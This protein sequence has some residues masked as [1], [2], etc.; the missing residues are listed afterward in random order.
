MNWLDFIIIFI[1]VNYILKGF[2]FGLVLSI[3][4]IARVILS[5][6]IT[7]KLYPVVYRYM[8]ES[9]FF[10]R[11]FE[12]IARFIS[13][14]FSNQTGQGLNIMSNLISVKLSEVIITSLLIIIIFLLVNSL[15]KMIVRKISFRI[16]IPILKQ[17]DKLGGIAF[18]LLEG[19]FVTLIIGFILS[20]IA[21]FFPES[22][23][24]SGVN[25]SL[26]LTY[27]LHNFNGLFDPQFNLVPG[28]YI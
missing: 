28:S 9:P 5:L 12:N 17:L 4:N 27:V 16:N 13:N 3:L 18:G 1:L 14:M 7:N 20:P 11:I 24:G 26:I 25:N 6:I 23:I 15:L 22:L 19:L 2:T 8:I 21:L 10:N